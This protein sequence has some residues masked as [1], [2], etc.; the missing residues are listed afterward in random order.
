MKKID[1]ETLAKCNGEDGNPVYVSHKGRVIDV[2]QSRLWKSGL[3]MN[4]HRA[5]EDLTTEIQAAPHGEE[6]LE[7]YPQVGELA[8]SPTA[9][10]MEMPVLLSRLLARFPMLRRHPHPMTV[11][12]PI[13][14]MV[15]TPVFTLLYLLTGIA[16]FETTALHCLGSGILFSIIAIATGLYTWWLNYQANPLRPVTIKKRLAPVMVAVSLIAFIWRLAVPGILAAMDL[17]GAV[18][19]IL[20]LSL[21]PLVCVVGWFGAEMTFPVEK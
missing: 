17:A 3:H 14:F 1:R 13:V 21:F 6:V 7:R 8:P 20:I 10:E 19:L 2:S 18:Y 9:E 4:R 15:S 11:H 16:A 5:G 12:F